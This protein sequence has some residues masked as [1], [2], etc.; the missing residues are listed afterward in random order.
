[1]IELPIPKNI[2]FMKYKRYLIALSLVITFSA[3]FFMFKNGLNWGIDFRGGVKLLYTFSQSEKVADGE[4]EAVLLGKGIDS[5]VQRYGSRDAN[6]FSVKTKQFD[7]TLEGT[8][9]KVSEVLA[10]KYGA[11]NVK[12][13]QQETVG[14]KV[15]QE[16]RR[17]GTLAVIFTLIAMLVY[18]GIRFDF[19]FAP[20]AVLG[21][22]H[23]VIVVMG[24]L[25]FFNKEYNLSILAAL[26]TIVGYSINDT[27]I[28][29]DRIR[30]HAKK[31]NANT[32][33]DIVNT[34]INETLSRT[35]IT[36]FTVLLVVVILFFSGGGVIHDFAFCFIV[37]VVTGSY[38]SVFIASSVYIWLYKNWP[39]LAAKFRR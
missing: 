13:E 35:I 36:S 20:G 23:D 39:K 22:L 5:I 1:M 9:D 29:Y 18:I 3:L 16:L 14:P 37:G 25:T 32:I 26:L 28:V 6:Q 17:K 11:E 30:E 8:V 7:A 24:F 31:I 38:S 19:Y 4:I 33:E 12:L 27:I 15:G 2:Q 10:V 34:S 21:L